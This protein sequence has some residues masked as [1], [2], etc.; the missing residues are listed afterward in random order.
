[1]LLYDNEC[2]YTKEM[3]AELG[4]EQDVIRFL[5]YNANK[6]MMNL[7]FEPV[8]AEETTRANA[9]VLAAL[10]SLDNHDFFSEAGSKYKMIDVEQTQPSDYDGI[11]EMFDLFQKT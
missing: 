3:Y 4:L 11:L 10:G 5:H 1:M 7:G 6:A 9:S 8:F 2:E